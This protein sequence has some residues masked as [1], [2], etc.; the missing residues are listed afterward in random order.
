MARRTIPPTTP[1][2]MA[3]ALLLLFV[4]EAE[5]VDGTVRLGIV[6]RVSNEGEYKD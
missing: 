2:A 6:A 4:E 1:P 3:P 5:D